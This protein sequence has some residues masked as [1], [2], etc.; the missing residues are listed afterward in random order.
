MEQRRLIFMSVIRILIVF[1]MGFAATGSRGSV[2][3]AQEKAAPDGAASAP[4]P[5]INVP[6]SLSLEEARVIID[7]AVAL[8]KAEKGRAAI[9]VVDYNGNLISLDSMD[10]SSRFWAR[11]AVGKAVGAAALQ[12]ATAV[13]AEQSKTNP[14][15]FHSAL[16]MLGG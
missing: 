5:L 15:R 11:F 12:V 4:R 1:I 7:A 9:A 2:A 16:S 3:S 6:T 8:V 14:A 10:G 13:S